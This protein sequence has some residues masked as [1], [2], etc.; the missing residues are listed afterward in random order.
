VYWVP[1]Y[2]H[3]VFAAAPERNTVRDVPTA[4]RPVDLD[5]RKIAALAATPLPDGGSGGDGAP[6]LPLQDRLRRGAKR[7]AKRGAPAASADAPAAKRARPRPWALPGPDP[8][9]PSGSPSGMPAFARCNEAALGVDLS[10]SVYA[11][12]RRRRADADAAYEAAA[13]AVGRQPDGIPIPYWGRGRFG[14]G[15]RLIFD[16]IVYEP[17]R[18]VRAAFYP[19]SVTKDGAYTAGVPYNGAEAVL[20]DEH[21]WVHEAAV[22]VRALMAPLAPLTPAATGAVAITVAA[23]AKERTTAVNAAGEGAPW[24]GLG[25]RMRGGTTTASC[26]PRCCRPRG[27]SGCGWRATP[28]GEPRWPWT[29]TRGGRAM[30]ATSGADPVC[31]FGSGVLCCFLLSLFCFFVVAFCLSQSFLRGA[32]RGCSSRSAP[33]S[34]ALVSQSPAAAQSP[35][36]IPRRPVTRAPARVASSTRAA[37]RARPSPAGFG[38]RP[39]RPLPAAVF[40]SPPSAPPLARSALSSR[41]CRVGDSRSVHRCLLPLRPWRR[42]PP[43]P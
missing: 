40:P 25:G 16:R 2:D 3:R 41:R 12:A 18:G 19:E 29:R 39:W 37:A 23:A 32:L 14:R 9:A 5:A 1:P 8:Y 33:F 42:P 31:H 35:R 34:S 27:T 4:P 43:S 15:A 6:P 10:T 36:G 7:G 28:R 20:E 26:W 21:D 22:E 11:D 13:A 24:R 17:E 30:S 38:R